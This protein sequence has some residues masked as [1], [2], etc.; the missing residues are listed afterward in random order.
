MSDYSMLEIAREMLVGFGDYVGIEIRSITDT[1]LTA[2][3]P[4][5]KE[6]LNL[7]GFAHGGVVNTLMD[8][9]S[10]ILSMFANHPPRRVVTRS[11]DMHFVRPLSGSSMRAEAEVIKHGKTCCLARAD[12]YDDQDRLCA[13][14]SFELVYITLPG[15][16]PI[17]ERASHLE[18]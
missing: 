6:Y 7:H 14:G 5:R 1:H 11:A 2:V 16:D 18:D 12:V 9:S 10:G 13:T 15:V 8:S 4:L 17:I 3:M